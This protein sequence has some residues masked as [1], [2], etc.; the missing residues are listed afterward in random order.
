MLSILNYPPVNC[1]AF[2][3]YPNKTKGDYKFFEYVVN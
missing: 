3:S 2:D 1:K